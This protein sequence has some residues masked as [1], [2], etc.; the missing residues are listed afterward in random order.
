MNKVRSK[1]VFFNFLCLF[2][3]IFFPTYLFGSTSSGQ[4]A[5]FFSFPLLLLLISLFHINLNNFIRKIPITI[6]LV[7]LLGCIIF[8]T[9]LSKLHFIDYQLFFNHLRFFAY[10]FIL[11]LSFS[12]NR[13]F[14]LNQNE[15]KVVLSVVFFF[16]LLFLLFQY[17]KPDS[18]I[19]QLVTKRKLIDFSGFR[20]GGPFDWSYIFAFCSIPFI[21]CFLHGAV[22][23][24]N[25]IFFNT[26]GVLTFFVFFLSQS[27]SA[28]IAFFLLFISWFIFN[29]YNYKNNLKL[30]A[31]CTFF[32]F[33][34]VV[35]VFSNLDMFSHFLNFIDSYSTGDTDASTTT[36][37]N[38]ISNINITLN[39]NFL[40]GTPNLYIVIENAYAHYLYNYGLLGLFCFI[41]LF[42][43]LFCDAVFKVKK[44]N[45]R[46]QGRDLGVYIGICCFIFSVFIFNLASSPV[47]ANKSSYFFFFIY[48]CY[49]SVFSSEMARI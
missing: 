38:Q 13:F 43:F 10:S 29:L 15:L 39:N 27:K 47:D 11:F 6:Y 45:A 44:M 22:R 2:Y 28:Y 9:T 42:L 36:R 1:V 33:V 7:L 26:I 17:L 35:F 8:I 34:V 4:V 24:E 19:I 14:S 16:V 25:S 21:F 48:G 41:S 30:I 18:T 12:L 3:L 40:M 5:L 46:N 23:Q 20:V 31:V 37:L 49:L 32:V